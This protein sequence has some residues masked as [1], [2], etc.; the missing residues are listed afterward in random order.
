MA[1]QYR[2]AVI[3]NRFYFYDFQN[4][5]L[6]NKSL[7]TFLEKKR[8]LLCNCFERKKINSDCLLDLWNT[9]QC[10]GVKEKTSF[11]FELENKNMFN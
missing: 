10:F 7:K 4:D 8:N 5:K 3:V 9:H 2:L 1:I 6:E 11:K